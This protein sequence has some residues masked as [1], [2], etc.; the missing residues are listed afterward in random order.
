VSN[1]RTLQD[2]F[3]RAIEVDAEHREAWIDTHSD[4]ADTAS[5]LRQLLA[6]H[7]LAESRGD[8]VRWD[9]RLGTL[10]A[11]MLTTAG[12]T[13]SAGMT[14]EGFT[15]ES[16]LGSGGMGEVWQA[17]Q[18]R[19]NRR[20]AIKILRPGISTAAILRRFE[21][22]A[23]ALARLD[24][25]GIAAIYD[26]GITDIGEGGM[27]WFAME[28]VEDASPITEYATNHDLPQQA[29]CGLLAEVC[30]AVHH[31]H[32]KGIVHRDLKPSN[33]LVDGGGRSRV[34]DFGVARC[35]GSDVA[36]TT[37]HTATGQLIGTLQYMSPEQTTGRD[38]DARSDVYALGV[39]L[40]ELV[41]GNHPYELDALPLTE[42]AKRVQE[43]EPHRLTRRCGLSRDI[44][45][46]V[47]TAMAK[48]PHRRYAS[49][50]AMAEDLR[51]I[52]GGTH[53]LARPPGTMEWIM[54]ASRR[55]PALAGAVCTIILLLVA[56]GITLGVMTEQAQRQAAS[57]K[58]ASAS[59]AWSRHDAAATMESLT[60]IPPSRRGWPWRLLAGAVASQRSQVGFDTNG[61]NVYAAIPAFGQHAASV[62]T[63][64]GGIRAAGTAT[65]TRRLRPGN[66]PWQ[67]LRM[68]DGS[69][70][71]LELDGSLRRYRL[72]E[73]TP[74]AS[75]AVYGTA[76]DRIDNTH[77]L[78]G[79][80]SGMLRV[81]DITT[82][83]VDSATQTQ[84]AGIRFVAAIPTGGWLVGDMRGAVVLVTSEGNEHVLGAHTGR[85]E[86]IAVASDGSWAVSSGLDGTLRR[87]DLHAK[88]AT[89]TV[90]P[91]EDMICDVAISADDSLIATC[92]GDRTV[93]VLDANTLETLQVFTGYDGMVWDVLFDTN[94][95][96]V[97][98][99]E[100]GQSGRHP[101]TPECVVAADS[102]QP[103]AASTE[104]LGLDRFATFQ[105][106]PRGRFI[107]AAEHGDSEF[108][109][110]R[111]VVIDTATGR[112][113]AQTCVPTNTVYMFAWS[114]NEEHIVIATRGSTL[115]LWDWQSGTRVPL[116]QKLGWA[117]AAA[118][119]PSGRKLAVS[120]Q[121]KTIL[122]LDMPS[123]NVRLRLTG[124]LALIRNLLWTPDGKNLISAADDGRVQVWDPATGELLVTLRPFRGRVASVVFEPGTESLLVEARDGGVYRLEPLAEPELP[125]R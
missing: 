119:D 110:S 52:E 37:V 67:G 1:A 53:V 113:M 103:N 91:H 69:I 40:Y 83:E 70:V 41:T 11:D 56:G 90:S 100:H 54:R 124:N 57:S 62:I 29:A 38:I 77:V 120:T 60:A 125:E 111:V 81:V 48:V 71:L 122:I 106:S 99:A 4:T 68:E 5:E 84:S 3:D 28:L 8:D 49:A 16:P 66:A 79:S 13:L 116:L 78:V 73:D 33:L 47:R 43:V 108:G 17:L 96:V 59:M 85:V 98:S 14:F 21:L 31:G 104:H 55:R 109:H 93:R 121:A 65:E 80:E 76:M 23:E 26:A 88:R 27:P 89:G 44:D 118:L 101:I 15:L 22:E 64:L 75:A 6:A 112:P 95:D 46:V 58:L 42:A 18:Y 39:V 34:I 114:P 72:G 92:G 19:P 107:A 36:V 102:A 10:R 30:D 105:R 2:L 50:A 74:S 115:W 45:A 51:R 97:T 86:G 63:D 61:T 94:G 32:I 7:D 87:W 82:M 35:T 117:N 12:T 123:G 24:H 20:V 25:P 9:E